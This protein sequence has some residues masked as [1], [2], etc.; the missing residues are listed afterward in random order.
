M[1]EHKHCPEKSNCKTVP[2]PVRVDP[3]RPGYTAPLFY[4][5]DR[6]RGMIHSET[7]SSGVTRGWSSL[8]DDSTRQKKTPLDVAVH[9]P[10]SVGINSAHDWLIHPKS[11]CQSFEAAILEL[12]KYD[13][14]VLGTWKLEDMAFQCS[15]R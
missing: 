4:S 11:I 1:I 15:L 7:Y 3:E 8:C 9:L 6:L 14:A 12:A 2:V 13:D 5:C 10:D